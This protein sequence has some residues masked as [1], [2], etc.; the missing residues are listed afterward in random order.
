VDLDAMLKE[1]VRGRADVSAL[2]SRDDRRLTILVWHYHDDD[3]AG[4]AADVVLNVEGLGVQRG[5]AKLQHFRIDAAHSNAYAAWL[6]MGS[7]QPP[8][9]AQY[10]ALEKASE[11]ARLDGASTVAVA[12]GRADVTF[13][14]PRQA[15]SLLVLEW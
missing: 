3:V 9:P 7:P 4:P 10:A 13:A 1:G 6:D 14:L 8:S 15:V 2:A 12:G 5:T 11:L